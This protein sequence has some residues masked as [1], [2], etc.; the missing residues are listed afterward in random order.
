MIGRVRTYY[1]RIDADDTDWVLSLFTPD[2][3]YERADA[4]YRGTEALREFFCILRR[5]RGAHTVE[6]IWLVD[7]ATVVVLG[8]FEGLGGRG[9]RRAVDFAD[10]WNFS[11]GEHVDHRRTYLALGHE[12]VQD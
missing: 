2:A 12:Y 7:A 6:R 8:R 10:V 5:I 1:D 3:V 11:D 9:D 4:T